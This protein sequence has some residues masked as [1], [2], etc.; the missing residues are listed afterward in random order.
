MI[1]QTFTALP[2]FYLPRHEFVLMTR[3][4]LLLT[5]LL[6]ALNCSANFADDKPHS[7]T[8]KMTDWAGVQELVR[9]HRGRVVVVNIWTTTCASCVKELPRFA[10]LQ[11]KCGRERL[12]CI[13]VNCDYDGI[14]GKPPKFYEKDVRAT[15]SKHG[16]GSENLM[17]K[18]AFIDFL[19]EVKL[20]STP[21]FYVYNA[22]GELLRRFDNDNA[23]SVDD[24]F[25][26]RDVEALVRKLVKQ[27]S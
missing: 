26:F 11:K 16:S 23:K 7:A 8:L 6:L 20:S 3:S 27:K 19:D 25:Q 1:L 5:A 14:E 2:S 22:K 18:T 21:A 4:Y 12:R 17:L 24:E 10:A 9:R 15:L 13:T